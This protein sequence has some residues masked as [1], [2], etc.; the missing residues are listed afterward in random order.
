MKE[1]SNK[2]LRIGSLVATSNAVSPE[3]ILEGLNRC[4]TSSDILDRAIRAFVF[5]VP[6]LKFERR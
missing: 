3:N 4:D 2:D 1:S 6:G 5:V